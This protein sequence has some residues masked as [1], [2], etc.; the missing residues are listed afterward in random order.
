MSLA[1]SPAAR[2]ALADWLTHLRA[3]DGAA[4]NTIKAYGTD[5]SGYLAFMACIAAKPRA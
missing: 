5:V 2:A 1:I 3:L 4:D